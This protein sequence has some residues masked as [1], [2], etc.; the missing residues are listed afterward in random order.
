MQRTKEVSMID[1]FSAALYDR[2]SSHGSLIEAATHPRPEMSLLRY[3]KNN[4]V[5]VAY[6][7]DKYQCL[8]EMA[9]YA[10]KTRREV[11]LDK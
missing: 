1:M 7:V 3:L 5:Y 9:V 2:M 4:K 11:I 8:V 10:S 6:R